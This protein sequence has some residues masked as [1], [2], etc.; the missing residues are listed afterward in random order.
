[1]FRARALPAQLAQ[2]RA[3]RGRGDLLD[4]LDLLGLLACGD[5]HDPDLAPDHV[6]GALLASEAFRH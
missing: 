5:V 4:V 6:G 2:R 3:S 1:M